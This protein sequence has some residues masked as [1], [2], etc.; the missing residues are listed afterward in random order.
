MAYL[1]RLERVLLGNLDVDLEG[2]A[3]I[4][5]VFLKEGE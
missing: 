4:A 5:C 1:G 2:S 3:F